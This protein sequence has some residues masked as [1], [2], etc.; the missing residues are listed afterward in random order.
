MS[1]YI[2]VSGIVLVGKRFSR[3]SNIKLGGKQ[4]STLSPKLF[5]IFINDAVFLENRWA[6]KVSL[7]TH[8]L[9]FLLFTDDIALVAS[10][11]ARFADASESHRRK[12]ADKK[13]RL[14]VE[15][16]EVVIFLEKGKEEAKFS[17]LIAPDSHQGYLVS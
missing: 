12:F 11:T 15:K 9:S 2:S 5:N 6:T 7:G 17:S 3:L 14:N 13:L 4:G 8:K 16:S 10:T 1:M